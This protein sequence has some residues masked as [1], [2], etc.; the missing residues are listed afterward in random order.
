MTTQPRR[1]VPTSPR[2]AARRAVVAFRALS[3]R[4]VLLDG[5][6]AHR[7]ELYLTDREAAALTEIADELERAFNGAWPNYSHRMGGMG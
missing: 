6:I 4:C 7:T 2:D 1:P 5:A 3:N